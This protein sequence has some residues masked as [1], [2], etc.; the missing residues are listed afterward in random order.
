MNS[1]TAYEKFA[2]DFL[3][4]RDHSLIGSKVIFKWRSTLPKKAEVLEIACGGGYP[5]TKS[6]KEA[7]LKIWA[8]DSSKTLLEKFKLRF[9]DIPA[10]CESVQ[11]S[12][13][14]GKKFDAVIGIGFL[15]LLP[16]DEQI[17]IIKKISDTVNSKGKFLFTA[18]LEV[19]GWKDMSTGIDCISLGYKKYA[20]ILKNAGFNLKSTFEDEGKNNY[21]E[22]EKFN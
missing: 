12:D 13:F 16:E 18:P 22:A 17:M 8:I 7:K 4:A 2:N 5:I 3:K 1:I 10:K 15:F 14:F 19:G 9:P 20:K 6:L 21:Y 11:D